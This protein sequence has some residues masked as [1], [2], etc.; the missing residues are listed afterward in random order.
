ME[1]GFFFFFI[2]VI[3]KILVST[4]SYSSSICMIN[5]IKK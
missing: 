4:I 1:S 2:S 3:L 5:Q